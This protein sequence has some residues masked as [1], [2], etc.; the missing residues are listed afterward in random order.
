MSYIQCQNYSKTINKHSVLNDISI[1]I[2]RGECVGL[3]G[4]NA[5]GKTMLLRAFAGLILPDHGCMIVGGQTL[6]TR[7]RFPE[8]MGLIIENLTFWPFMTGKDALTVIASVKKTANEAKIVETLDRVGLDPQDTRTIRKYSL[9]MIQKL[10]I[11]Q[12]IME[13]P[14]LL[15]LDEPTNALDEKSRERFYDMIQEEQKRGVT[16][17]MASHN[18]D[19]LERCCHRVVQI[20]G[21][22]IH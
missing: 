20:D 16:L 4:R 3:W 5:S 1:D 21:G 14:D 8:S 22:S 10:A 12:A 7:H 11:A 13:S 17:V 19:D 2:D 6:T 15:L 18:R 9:G